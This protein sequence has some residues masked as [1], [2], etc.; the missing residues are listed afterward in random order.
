MAVC[1]LEENYK[2]KYRC[3]YEFINEG[4]KVYIEKDIEDEAEEKNE[5]K[6]FSSNQEIKNRNITIIDYEARKNYKL[7]HA[8]F[9]GMKSVMGTPDSTNEMSFFANTYFSCNSVENIALLKHTP[10][11]EKVKIFNNIVND[12]IGFP[13]FV[14]SDNE[15]ETSIKLLKNSDVQQSAN[16][17]LNYIDRINISDHWERSKKNFKYEIDLS[18]YIELLFSRKINYEDLYDYVKELIIYM[19]LFV[20]NKFKIN[21]ITTCIESKYYELVSPI[22]DIKYEEKHIEHTVNVKL[23]DFLENCYKN[24]P[25][26]KGNRQ[27]RNIPF[28]LFNK[29][30]NIEDNFLMFYRFIECYY[31]SQSDTTNFILHSIN[32]CSNKIKKSVSDLDVNMLAQEIVCLRNYYVHSGYHLK[33]HHLNIK[34]KKTANKENLKNYVA[35]VNFDWIYTRTTLLY[36]IVIDIIF[37]DMLHYDE[38]SF[39][40][41]F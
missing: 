5:Y 33:G 41:H 17:N 40:N 30:R 24:I 6:F 38:Y 26:V 34:F 2:I 28:I 32:K 37:K 11:I 22:N 36:D 7:M 23:I 8:Y 9:S 4:L 20:P 3:T 19:Q 10:K 15:V 39:S 14:F 18:G 27:T 16:I 31:K 21:K 29:S 13:S 35:N 12:F 1:F 25:Y